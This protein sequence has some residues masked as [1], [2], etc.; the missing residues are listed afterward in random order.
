MGCPYANIFGQPYKGVHQTRFLGFAVFDT[1]LT[2]LAAIIT[3]WIFKGNFAIHL[4]VWLIAGEILHYLFGVRTAFLEGINLLP[5]CARKCG[6]AECM[7]K[8]ERG[9]PTCDG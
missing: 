5:E 8:R 3:A 6:C 2:I 9:E 1:V 7:K 4:L